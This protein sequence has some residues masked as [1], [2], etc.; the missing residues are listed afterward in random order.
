MLV[1]HLDFG[2]RRNPGNGGLPTAIAFKFACLV[3]VGLFLTIW[4]AMTKIIV[5][6]ER[7]SLRTCRCGEAVGTNISSITTAAVDGL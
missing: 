6:A 1:L 4:L 7:F 5:P 3:S 2:R